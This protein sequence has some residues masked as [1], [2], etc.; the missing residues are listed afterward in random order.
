MSSI[1][2]KYIGETEKNLRQ[3]FDSAQRA[4]YILY[5]DKADA[6]F[7]KSKEDSHDRYD[8]ILLDYKRPVI[9]AA[10]FRSEMSDKIKAKGTADFRAKGANFE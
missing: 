2:S 6:L 1:V 4:E 8:S 3:I 9:L 10:D 7:G 5:F